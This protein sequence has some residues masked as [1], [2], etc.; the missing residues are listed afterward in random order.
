[1]PPEANALTIKTK[2]GKLGAFAR[3]ISDGDAHYHAPASQP[4]AVPPKGSD[5]PVLPSSA[6]ARE[7]MAKIA[8]IPLPLAPRRTAQVHRLTAPPTQPLPPP[9]PKKPPQESPHR[10]GEAPGRDPTPESPRP[11]QDLIQSW[12]TRGMFAGSQ[13]GDD[14]M[15]SGLTSG[16]TT[17]HNEPREHRRQPEMTGAA[18]LLPFSG[19]DVD[20]I[21]DKLAQD[22]PGH[23]SEALQLKPRKTSAGSLADADPSAHMAD[24]FQNGT[25]PHHSYYRAQSPIRRPANLPVREEPRRARGVRIDAK[26]DRA[27]S[28]SIDYADPRRH[29]RF[30]SDE[31]DP[32]PVVRYAKEHGEDRLHE[33]HETPKASRR[34]APLVK[35]PPGS[36]TPAAK[37]PASPPASRKRSR[38]T[39]DYDDTVLGTKTF[40]DLQREPFDLDPAK[41]VI[42]NGDGS[43]GDSLSKRL[44]KIQSQPEREQRAYFGTMPLDEWEASGDWFVDQFA[45]LMNRFKDARKEKR[46]VVQGFEAEAARREQA[47]RLRAEAIDDKLVK[48][49]QDGQRVVG[50][51]VL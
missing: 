6:P 46:H 30:E 9:S 27:R 7:D 10:P 45:G 16:L 40:S 8:R 38:A 39:P 37:E 23:R 28:P 34:H 50:S 44:G 13:L 11:V 21:Y 42:L 2:S 22:K 26:R 24:G 43:D 31:R 5:T 12:H 19:R 51:R 17:P 41:T 47:V 4:D 36:P 49:R 18:G 25:N 32:A 1:M 15:A 48:M 35:R 14:F 3:G 20:L 29:L 33:A